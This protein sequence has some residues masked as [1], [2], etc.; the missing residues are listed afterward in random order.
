MYTHTYAYIYIYIYIYRERER[1]ICMYVYI[2]IYIY[3]YILNFLPDPRAF[4]YCMRISREKCW[5]YY[6]LTHRSMYLDMGFETINLNYCE[7][8]V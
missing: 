6:G 7:L 2:Y 3:I 1:H 5:I 4:D 8:K